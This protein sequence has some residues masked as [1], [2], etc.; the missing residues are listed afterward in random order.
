[1]IILTNSNE[2]FLVT[3]SDSKFGLQFDKKILLKN[4]QCNID[5]IDIVE[6]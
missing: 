5:A 6:F 1:M 3:L 2:V 4:F